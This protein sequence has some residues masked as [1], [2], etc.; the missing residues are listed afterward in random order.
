[1]A[2]SRRKSSESP[3]QVALSRF[4]LV[5][6]VFGLW[7][8][9]IGIR[10]VY[11]Q[12]S[13]HSE[14]SA[15]AQDQR[16]DPVRSKMLRGT[17]FDRNERTL[18]ISIRTKSL[19]ADPTMIEN[20]DLAAK[21]LAGPLG[22][23]QNELAKELRSSKQDG[24]RFLWIARK[25]EE[26]T[27]AKVNEALKGMSPGAGE[28]GL[29][30]L[31]WRDEQKRS[32][33]YQTLAAHILGFSNSD[34][35]GQAGIEQSQEDNLR[36]AVVK[37]WQERDRLGRILETDSE[38][39]ESPKNIVLTISNSIQYKT[40]KALAE[41]ARAA[42]A[43][44]AM[45]V[46][47][48]PRTGEILAMANYPTFDPNSYAQAK[49]EVWM[50]HAVQSIYAPGSVFKLITYSSA[51]Q[52]NL[53]EVN[54]MID[55]SAGRIDV[56][57]HVFKD[58]HSIGNVSYIDALAHSSNVAAIRTGLRVG[59][60]RF[61]N[62]AKNFGFGERTGI[63]L[64]G[65]VRGQFR[66][67][68]RWAGD[69]LGSMSIGYEMG[70]TALQMTSAFATIANDG[71]RVQPHVVKEVRNEDGTVASVPEVPRTQVV[72]Q[73]TAANVRQMLRQVVMAGTGRRAQ[74]NGYTSAGKTGTA[75]KFNPKLKKV[76]PGKYVSSFI[77]FAPAENP[78]VVIAVVMD[79]PAV[80]ARDG[81]TVSAPVFR[82]IAEQVLPELN[83]VPDGNIKQ[84]P[85][86]TVEI[87]EAVVDDQGK[88]VAD[89]D[90]TASDAGGGN[91]KA[92]DDR[93]KVPNPKPP[94]ATPK[95]ATDNKKNS[96]KEK[97]KN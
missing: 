11:L 86:P 13:K 66:S 70:V 38:E 4:L 51:L 61:Y 22:L 80:G 89:D 3:R 56:A 92:E 18:A 21:K 46:V 8:L 37:G 76:D 32:Y 96:S 29:A 9:G 82:E 65:E 97:K 71:V 42:Y 15:K 58:S 67:P 64:P 25:L 93:K 27:V 48:D 36:G 43:R 63:E 5:V 19:A 7:I 83:I 44:S 78:A 54:Q 30:G 10:L 16:R 12:I 26:E 17:I 31:F 87:P 41:G 6:A 72:S 75:W 55:C 39:R 40:E 79:E 91:K 1:M 34:D 20:V 94:A 59:K 84:A 47:M 73:E 23:K 88:G 35:V 24:K 33:P 50:N 77:G 81:G 90:T 53:I 49:P 69:S 28:P 2:R 62:Y 57:G 60:D 52:E 95:T 85:P 68:E 74:L 45:A 14:L